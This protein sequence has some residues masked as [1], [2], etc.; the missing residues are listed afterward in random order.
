MSYLF[1]LEEGFKMS[2]K[3]EKGE[4][5]AAAKDISSVDEMNAYFYGHIQY[6]GPV[7]KV[8]RLAQVDLFSMM[9]GHDIGYWC[10]P[11]VISAHAKI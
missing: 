2:G 9:I 5:L 11:D 4:S 1:D 10:D 7:M 6:P 3:E 8:E